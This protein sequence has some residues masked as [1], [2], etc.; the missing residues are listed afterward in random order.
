[1]RLPQQ[2]HVARP[3]RE[4]VGIGEQHALGLS[5]AKAERIA[6]GPAFGNGHCVQQH[7]AG[8]D[9][10]EQG[11]RRGAG[12]D[13]ELAGADPARDA[14]ATRQPHPAAGM[15]EQPLVR[16]PAGDRAERAARLDRDDARG[17]EPGDRLVVAM[18]VE[19]AQ[20]EQGQRQGDGPGG[21][22]HCEQARPIWSHAVNPRSVPAR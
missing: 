12:S 13:L 10:L 22:D 17:I 4:P 21:Q 5:L 9:L 1:V 6:H 15:V 14:L 16:E 7:P 19:P 20:P 11:P 8:D 18:V 3:A 2:V